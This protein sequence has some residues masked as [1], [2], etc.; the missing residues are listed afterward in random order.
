MAIKKILNWIIPF[1][2]FVN[3]ISYIVCSIG[4]NLF[5]DERLIDIFKLTIV[6]VNLVILKCVFVQKL[7]VLQKDRNLLNVLA[8]FWV[9]ATLVIMLDKFVIIPNEELR[10]RLDYS[11]LSLIFVNNVQLLLIYHAFYSPYG[12]LVKWTLAY[13]QLIMFALLFFIKSGE[14]LS[15]G[16][17]VLSLL[18][19]FTTMHVWLSDIMSATEPLPIFLDH[20]LNPIHSGY[21]V[22]PF[23]DIENNS[24]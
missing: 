3:S 7:D 5:N 21:I 19:S 16:T 4:R 24:K 12:F 20:D 14:F 23:S 13:A 9:L 22:V 10:Q 6:S 1:L 11:I 18:T 17:L 8:F 15:I 2:F